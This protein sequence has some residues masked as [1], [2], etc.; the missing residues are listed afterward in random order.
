M[1]APEPEALTIEDL[2][3]ELLVEIFRHIKAVV[4][5]SVVVRVSVVFRDAAGLIL[6]TKVGFLTPGPIIRSASRT[7]HPPVDWCELPAQRILNL[8]RRLGR[9]TRAGAL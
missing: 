1:Q 9:L 5:L 4:L 3:V 8:N 2:P 6:G 7:Q